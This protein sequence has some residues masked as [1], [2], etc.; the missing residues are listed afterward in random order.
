MIRFVPDINQF[1]AFEPSKMQP[2]DFGTLEKTVIDVTPSM[3]MAGNANLPAVATPSTAVV[4]SKISEDDISEIGAGAAG[5]LTNVSTKLLSH[6]KSTDAGE[7]GAKLNELVVLAK[8]LDPK[9]MKSKGLIGRI[10]G[11][12]SLTKEKLVAQYSTVENQMDNLTGQLDGSVALFKARVLDLDGLYVS[13]MQYHQQ[14]EQA[15]QKCEGLLRQVEAEYEVEKTKHVENSFQAQ[16]LGDYQRKMDHIAKRID[17]LNRAMMLSKQMAPRIREMQDNSRS[18]VQKFGEIKDVTLP[19]WKNIFS[20]YVLQLE[21][22]RGVELANAVDDATDEALKRGA[23][24]QRE[25]AVAIATSRNR[26]VISMEAL[27]HV[28]A[29]MLGAITDVQRI[30]EEGR[31]QRKADAPKLL[32][33]EQELIKAFAPGKR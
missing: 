4:A 32:A 12:V 23:D 2:L 5:A 31:A 30:D 6:V 16:T 27:E 14:L 19:A 20:L 15:V 24:L 3:P 7:F 11:A 25:N 8:G 33:M 21:Q 18:L 26:S 1:L 17:S 9:D 29:Q 28:Q 22:K 13:N 10:F